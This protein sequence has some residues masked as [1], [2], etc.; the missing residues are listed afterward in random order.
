LH[1][2]GGETITVYFE[3]RGGDFQEVFMEGGAT[4]A[5]EGELWEEALA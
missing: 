2:W 3:R 1:T 5:Y 4:V